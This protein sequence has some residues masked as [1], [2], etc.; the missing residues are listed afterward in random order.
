MWRLKSLVTVGVIALV[1]V[2]GAAV[3]FAGEWWWNAE[4]DV[5]GADVRTIWTVN[6]D[7][8]GDNYE[9]T[10]DVALPSG[11]QAD[12]IQSSSNETVTLSTDS[13]L[14]CSADSVE[15]IVTFNVS[16]LPGATGNKAKVD[17]TSDGVNIGQ[18]TGDLNEDIVV[19][20]EIPADNPSCN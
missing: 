8:D 11:A 9:A 15:A 12:I 2:I 20:V 14:V 13:S 19:N 5:E 4:L 1:L 18:A 10:I 7:P 16:P 17:V 6:A 3:V